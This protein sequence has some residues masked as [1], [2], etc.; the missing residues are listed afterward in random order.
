MD[1]KV[2]SAAKITPQVNVQ[3]F[4]EGGDLVNDLESVVAFKS[5]DQYGEPLTV[6]GSITDASGAAITTFSSDHDGMGL[7]R[8]TPAA[9]KAYTATVTTANGKTTKVKLPAARTEG[10]VM[11]IN[12]NAAARLT[13]ILQRKAAQESLYN[14]L[15]IVAQMHN[16]IVFQGEVNFAEGASAASIPK[17]SLPQALC[18]SLFLIASAIH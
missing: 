5:Y 7:F 14:R 16:T 12:N 11:R 8:L 13:V 4:P 18:R 15:L 1:R 9:A 6:T 10:I 2:T 3:F 17:K